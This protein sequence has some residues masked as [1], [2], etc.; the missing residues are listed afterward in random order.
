MGSNRGT[1]VGSNIK[2]GSISSVESSGETSEE[3]NV[4][5]SGEASER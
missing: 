5:A 3:L 2:T 4:D 1:D